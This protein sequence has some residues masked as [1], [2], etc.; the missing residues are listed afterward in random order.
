MLSSY[1]DLTDGSFFMVNFTLDHEKIPEV[2]GLVRGQINHSV[3]LKPIDENTTN[4]VSFV[5]VDPMGSIPTA[6]VNQM[7]GM[8]FE[9]YKKIKNI[10]EGRD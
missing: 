8:Q 2:S 7:K 3:Y 10:L 1:V 6:F 4:W 9:K 5:N